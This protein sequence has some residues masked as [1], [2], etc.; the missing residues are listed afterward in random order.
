MSPELVAVAV[1][2][3]AGI[4]AVTPSTATARTLTDAGLR[5]DP[6]ALTDLGAASAPAV[7][8]LDDE[9]ARAGEHAE[10]LLAQ[11]AQVLVRGGLVVAGARGTVHAAVTGRGRDPGRTFTAVELSRALGHHGFAVELLCAP[12]AGRA[13]AGTAAAYEPDTD[14]QPGLLDA[15][16]HVV[17]AGRR[18]PDDAARSA[19]FFS[20]LP[21]KVVAA[22]TL[23]H[24]AQGRLLCVHDSFKRHWTIP[25][26]VVDA[27]EDP[28]TGAER[29]TWEEAGL[30]VRGGDLLGVFAA[31]W[32]DRLIL[33]YAATALDDTTQRL[34]PRHSHEIDDVAWLPHDEAL[35]RLAPHK[36]DQVRR[37]L[38]TPGGTWRQG[39]VG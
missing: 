35:A 30:R 1:E 24:D 33:I 32:P 17:A 8:L 15:A 25:G 21:R 39:P 5:V 6:V 38:D 14:R 27:D 34:I 28:R 29:E 36:A 22:A 13:L 18:Y 20:S 3:L 37:C 12:G 9:L 23:C 11:A 10:G 4:R 2:R 16:P 19:A 26:G 31:S 7:V